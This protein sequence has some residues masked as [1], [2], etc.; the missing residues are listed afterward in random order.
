[1]ELDDLKQNWQEAGNPQKLSPAAIDRITGTKYRSGLRRITIPETTGVVICVAGAA[2]IVFHFN[3]L[4]TYFLQVVG[5]GTV[6]LLLLLS[7]ISLVSLKRLTMV[8]D[9]N[10]PYAETL[11]QFALQKSKF[12]KLQRINVTLCYLLLVAVIVLFTKMFGGNDIS[13]S[14][15]FWTF[16]LCFGYIFLLFFSKWISKYYEATVQ[17]AEDLLKE[18]HP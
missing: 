13:S 11:R 12:Y 15:H 4:D 16:S 18:L 3:R 9:L 10:Q 17:Q 7:A 14:K 6:L 5:I 8:G 1:M 2:Y